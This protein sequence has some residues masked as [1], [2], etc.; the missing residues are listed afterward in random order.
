[1]AADDEP[2]DLDERF[3]LTVVRVGTER[4]PIV[5]I[6]NYLKHAEQLAAAAVPAA[7]RPVEGVVYP[8]TRAPL[9][10]RYD[11]TFRRTLA[12]RV[13]EIFGFGAADIVRSQCDFSIV[14]VRP[15]NL[16]A[17][18][19]M[20]HFD[21]TE[22]TMVAGIHF[23]C[24]PG[25]GGTSFY[26]HRRTGYE[27]ITEARK[28][29][30]LRTLKDEA[31][32][33]GPPPVAYINGETPQFQRIASFDAAFNRMLIYPGSILHSGNIAADFDFDPDPGTGRLT[34]NTFYLFGRGQP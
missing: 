4:S 21:G 24:S 11:A 34:A 30:Y 15:E 3:E 16:Q 8:G 23:L 20:P 13:R 22:P 9:P 32:T 5:V 31:T 28:N 14:T 6:E 29:I 1:M 26:R 33:M 27:N 12:S 7:F 25:K 2:F 18:Q 10:A 17:V 19:R